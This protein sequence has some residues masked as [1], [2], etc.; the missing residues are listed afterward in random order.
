MEQVVLVLQVQNSMNK[1]IIEVGST[2][3]KIDKY[4]GEKVERLKE[5]TI[6]FKKHYK[7][8]GKIRTSDLEELIKMKRN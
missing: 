6:F 8:D 5:I 2:V 1:I 7:E 3:T 4:D